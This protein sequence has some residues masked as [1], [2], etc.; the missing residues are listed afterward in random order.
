VAQ[1]TA[2][3]VVSVRPDT[4]AAAAGL[5]IG[6]VMV[7][8]AGHAIAEPEDLVDVLGPERVGST[9]T[10]SLLRG[11]EPRDV[12]VTVGERPSRP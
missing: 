10:L 8:I 4:P 3:I 5:L 11:G 2:L 1:R 9:V 6:D 7:S 12:A